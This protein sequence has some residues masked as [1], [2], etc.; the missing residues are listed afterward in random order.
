MLWK[1][2]RENL[3][4]F[5]PLLGTWSAAAE[6]QQGP[7]QC[8]RTFSK[9]LHASH[10]QLQAVWHMS[11]M[12]YEETAFFGVD[13]AGVLRFWSFTSD[14]KQSQ[15]LLADVSAIHPEAFGFEAQMP[16]GLARMIYWPD[17]Q[18]GFYWAVESYEKEG[19]DR[20]TEHQYHK[21]S[22]ETNESH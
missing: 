21:I 18:G 11:K 3:D 14:G 17:A 15:G 22:S 4:L 6:S 20:F 19:W 16:A 12:I 1:K 9:V 8:E 13:S 5:A 7:V 2:G 10:I